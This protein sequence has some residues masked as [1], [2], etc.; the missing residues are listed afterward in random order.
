MF[1]WHSWIYSY[2]DEI[3]QFNS[4]TYRKEGNRNPTIITVFRQ[5]KPSNYEVSTMNY[6]NY[7][8]FNNNAIINILLVHIIEYSAS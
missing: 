2:S 5:L 1:A 3:Q 4:A 7:E 6:F 8:S